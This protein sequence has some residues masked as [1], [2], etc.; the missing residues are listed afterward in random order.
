MHA[1][2]RELSLLRTGLKALER[3]GSEHSLVARMVTETYDPLVRAEPSCACR[4]TVC[5]SELMACCIA[6]SV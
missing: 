1:L 3:E 6:K 2:D 4:S 5:V